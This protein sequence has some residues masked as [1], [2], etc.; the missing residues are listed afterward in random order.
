MRIAI[1][2]DLAQAR[3]VLRRLVLSAPE[4]VLAWMAADGA[5]AVRKA[6][7]DRPDVILMDLVMPVMDG[8]D[9]TRLIMSQSPCP[10]LLLTSSVTG[11]FDMVYRAMGCGGL[12]VVNTPTL[13]PK[14]TIENG[15][16]IL[17]RIARLARAQ[18]APCPAAGLALALAG[19]TVTMS[20]HSPPPLVAIGA[21]TGGPE[22]VAQIL[23]AL[24]GSL[25]AAVIVVQHIAAEFA[26]E[27]ARWLARHGS[28]P[29][30]LA[31]DLDELT[32]G[33]VL[34]A[35]TE[36]HLVLRGDRRLVYTGDPVDYPYCPS[37]DVLFSSLAMV[38]PR[39]GV[40]ALLTGMG[41]D[42]A[43]G[44][45]QLRKRGWLTIAQDQASSVVYDM[46]KAAADLDAA[47][48]TL[49]PTAIAAALI[50]HVKS[51]N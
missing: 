44:L 41:T 37:V 23:A 35:G 20:A 47:S 49:N 4:H 34:L 48:Q 19:G 28:L 29:V 39:K 12:D 46:P 17:T 26:P 24:P 6:A 13:G 40:A 22:V 10:I 27:L 33:E 3:V 14:Q 30:R 7:E 18:E 11:N 45:L 50:N 31:R 9:A 1:V 5:E 21:S 2:N 15:D 42:G 43:R 25:G 8:V 38:G 51:L 32:P 16:A 36:D